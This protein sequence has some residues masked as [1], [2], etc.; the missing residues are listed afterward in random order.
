ANPGSAR[1]AHRGPL[2]A[3]D[4]ARDCDSG[5]WHRAVDAAF[6][7]R[8]AFRRCAVIDTHAHLDACAEPAELLVERAHEVG[9][10]RIISVGTRTPSWRE[11]IAIAERNEGVVTA[12]GVHPHE[13]ADG[14]LAALRE[15]LEH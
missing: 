1:S 8:R 13:A 10:T 4:Q 7:A 14:D 11:T 3:A 15:A 5:R 2:A 12:L 9:V 6:S